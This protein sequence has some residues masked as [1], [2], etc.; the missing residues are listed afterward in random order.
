M[1][2]RATQ[3][4]PGIPPVRL[5]FWSPVGTPRGPQKFSFQRLH[6]RNGLN[7]AEISERLYAAE[8]GKE[9]QSIHADGVQRS[10]V[11][12]VAAADSAEN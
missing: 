8:S 3:H 5:R 9:N 7:R 4:A 11:G 10:L 1:T 2:A 12:E 6:G